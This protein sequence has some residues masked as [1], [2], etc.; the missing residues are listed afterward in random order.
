MLISSTINGALRLIGVLAAGEEAS[1]E[2]HKDALERLNGMIEGFNIQNLTVSYLQEKT[3]DAPSS[4]WTS[5]I[6]IGNIT[7]N[8]YIETAPISIASA[9][10]RDVSGTDFPLLPMGENQWSAINYK[11]VVAIPTRYFEVYHGVTLDLQFD[12]IPMDGYVLHLMVKL[13]YVGNYLPTDNITWDY[14]FEEMLR[15]QLAVRLAPE[16]GVQLRQEVAVI[17]ME[18]MKNIKNRNATNIFLNVDN[19][20]QNKTHGYYNINS[21]TNR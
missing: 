12:T 6:T 8:T 2:E 19:G 16:Y 14:G 7:G 17:A 11:N 13:P 10:F 15:Y 18:L 5:R 1:P 20:L 9:F 4:G 3:Y 21:G